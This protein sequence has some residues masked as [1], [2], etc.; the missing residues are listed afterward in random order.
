MKILVDENIPFGKEVFAV[1]IPSE[2]I[3]G[4]VQLLNGREINSSKCKNVDA[5]IV[6]SIT[7]VNEALLKNSSVKFV[8]TTTIGT[9]HIDIEYLTNSGT[10]FSSAGGC[11]SYS[12]AE[13]VFS[14]IS[15][16]ANKQ[17]FILSKLSIE[18]G[19]AS[20]RERV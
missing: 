3:F 15:Y 5:L 12:V 6:R 13:Y 7:K 18:I 1:G 19:R 4:E 14:A 20:C 10:V 8:G 11:N 17:K 16:L 2:Q 9:D